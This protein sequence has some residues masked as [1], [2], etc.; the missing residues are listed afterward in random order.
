MLVPLGDTDQ[1]VVA[2]LAATLR[3]RL[4]V[5]V[6]VTAHHDMPPAAWYAPRQRWRAEKILD[7][8]DVLEVGPAW[9]VTA[10]T[11]Q[12]IST[13]KG[14]VYDW[15][16]AGL[17]SLGGRSSVLSAYYFRRIKQTSRA[18][19]RRYLDNLI[20]HE[21]GHTLGLDHCPLPRCIMAD[22]KGKAIRAAKLSTNEFCPRCH[23]KLKPH[24]RAATVRGSWT[25]QERDIIGTLPW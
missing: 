18:R 3:D 1:Q 7:W 17:G 4:R 20:L 15:G 10:F 23:H 24:L 5:Q 6:T 13:T 25:Q 11:E 22:A 12:R 19:Y 21:V 16:I 8:L 9:R 14:A 2:D